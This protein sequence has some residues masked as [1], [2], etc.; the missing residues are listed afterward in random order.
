[1]DAAGVSL[2]P[3]LALL[4]C[5]VLAVVAFRSMELPPMLGYLLTGVVLGPHAF[6]L[7]PYTSE[8]RH[9]AE[10]GIVFLMFSIGLEFS[11]PKLTAMRRVVFGL[12]LSQVFA[13]MAIGVAIGLSWERRG[14]RASC[15][16]AR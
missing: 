4:A 9:L 13:T 2:Q 15:S 8:T 11:L 12:G 5:A 14:R 7:I 1:M 6:G 16:A 3:V 10:F